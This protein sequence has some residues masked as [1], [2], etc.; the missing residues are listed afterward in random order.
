MT[1]ATTSM[2][3]ATLDQ[4]LQLNPALAQCHIRVD[5]ETQKGS[6]ID[7]I[8]LVTGSSSAHAGQALSRLPP[9]MSARCTSLRINGKGKLTPVAD[10]LTLIEI[11]WELPG[12]AAKAFRRQSA[13][14]IARY[15][16]ADR[17]LIDE[18]EARYE[19]VPAA[20]QEFMQAHVERPEVVPLTES[21]R[22]RVLKR[23]REDL[24]EL[25]LDARLKQAGVELKEAEVKLQEAE[26]KLQAADAKLKDAGRT[27]EHRVVV[28]ETRM[29]EHL[30]KHRST[31]ST[32]LIVSARTVHDPE[33]QRLMKTDAHIES[34]FND[35][36]KQS[37]MGLV[38]GD[39]GAAASPAAA[40]VPGH[41]FCP[42]FVALCQEMG[43]GVPPRSK[44][45]AIGKHAAR[46]FR[47]RCPRPGAIH[48]H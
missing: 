36:L 26:V 7:V 14:L 42:D 35:Y 5:Q 37:M 4:L 43:Y 3:D 22:T 12:K 44:L 46:M 13:H 30:A 24:E 38:Y 6:V 23:K 41:D 17:T 20:A 45:V 19:R 16:G 27:E 39:S 31:M 21:E 28:H 1:T 48:H 8:R 34:V 9:E 2:C 10:A 40:S 25:E 47:D 29:K 11:V 15:L 32:E 18:I 33:I